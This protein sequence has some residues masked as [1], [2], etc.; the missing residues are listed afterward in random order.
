MSAASQLF[1]CRELLRQHNVEFDPAATGQWYFLFGATARQAGREDLAGAMFQEAL[2]HDPQLDVARE[3]LDG[4]RLKLGP[5]EFGIVPAPTVLSVSAGHVDIAPSAAAP[6]GEKA[7]AEELLRQALEHLQQSRYAD[8][9]R[10]LLQAVERRP[11]YAEAYAALGMVYAKQKRLG[12]AEACFRLVLQLQPPDA[13]VLADLGMICL[14]NNKATEAE[15]HLRQALLLAPNEPEILLR[16]ARTLAALHRG[17]EAESYLRTSLRLN[18]K[19]ADGQFLFGQWLHDQGKHEEA[20]PCLREALSLEPNHVDALNALGMVLESRGKAAEAESLYRRALALQPDLAEVHSNLGVALAEQ[21]KADE[22]EKEYRE[23]IRLKPDSAIAYSNL[24]NGL[25]QLGRLQEAEESLRHA[26]RLQR[27]YAEAHNNLG[28]VL[29]Q[30]GRRAEGKAC[31]EEALRLKPAYAD[32]HLNLGLYYLGEGDFERGWPEYEWRFKTRGATPRY[33]DRLAW[34]GAPFPGKTLLLH[35]EQGIGDTLQFIR[36]ARLAK[37]RGGNVA[38]ECPASLAGLFEKCPGVDRVFLRGEQPP[39]FDLHAPLMSL[40]GLLG[41]RLNTIPAPIPYLFPDEKGVRQWAQ[42]LV[43]IDGLRVGIVWQG[44]PQ[45]KGDRQRSAPLSAFAPLA[46]VPGVTLC[47]LQKDAGREQ[48]RT[49]EF[50]VEDFGARLKDQWSDTAA[51]V[52]NLDLLISV[53]TAVLHLAGAMGK[54][55]WGALPFAADWRWLQGRSDSP[56]Y[57]SIRLFRQKEAGNWKEVF[58]ALAEKLREEAARPRTRPI[59]PEP[60]TAAELYQCGSAYFRRGKVENALPLFE[61]AVALEPGR[62]DYCNSLGAALAK[63]KRLPEAEACFRQALARKPGDLALLGN[64]ALCCQEQGKKAEAE[65]VYRE[66]SERSPTSTEVRLKLAGVLRAQEKKKEAEAV[67]REVVRLQPNH[68]DA[69]NF[70]GILLEDTGKPKEAEEVYRQA[71]KVQPDVAEIHSNLGVALAAQDRLPEA[72]AAYR[73]ALRRRPKSAAAHNNLGNTLRMLGN[74]EEAEE[75]LLEAIRLKSDYAEA[76]NNLGVVH[77][78]AARTTE[79]LKNYDEALRLKPDYAEAHLNRSLA[80]LLQGDF[81]RGWEEYEWRWRGRQLK[82][83]FTQYPLWKGETLTGKTILLHAEQGLGD[84][85]QFVRYASIL[86]ERGARV[87][88]ECPESLVDLFRSCDGVDHVVQRGHTAPVVDFQIP[89]INVPGVLKTTMATIP[90]RVPYL[91]PDS[92]RVARWARELAG[93]GRIRV[94]IVWQGNP[95]HKGDRFRSVPLAM[96]APLAAVPD[97]ILCSIQKNHGREQLEKV[98]FR[99]EDFGE[100]V[101]SLADTAALMANLDLIISVDTAVVH[102]AGALARPVWVALPFAPDWRWLRDIEHSPW[103]PTLRHFRKRDRGDWSEVFSRLE[104]ALREFHPESRCSQAAPPPPETAQEWYQLGLVHYKRAQYANAIA[105]L[106]KAITLNPQCSDYYNSLGAAQAKMKRLAEAEQSFRKVL[107][108]KPELMPALGNLGLC[109]YEQGKFA[110]AEQAYREMTR[111]APT[112]PEVKQKLANLLRIQG[113]RQEA[114]ECYRDLLKLQ[115]KNVELLNS[116][117]ILLEEQG[118]NQ[119][120]IDVYRQALAIDPNAAEIHSNLG[121]A[122][123]G[124]ERLDQ[125]EAAYREAI[126]LKPNSAAA[127]NNLGNVLRKRGKVPEAEQ[128]LREALRLQA[129]YPEACNNLGIVLSHLG[130]YDESVACYQQALKLRPDYPEAL[131]NYG[132]L[133]AD[134][135]DADE[136]LRCYDEAIRIRPDYAEAHLNRALTY[137]VQGDF[138]RGWPEYEWRWKPPLWKGDAFTDRRWDGGSLKGCT[139]LLRAEQGQGDTIQF[140]RF[141]SCLKGQCEAQ[142]VIVEC[143]ESLAALLATCSGVDEVVVRGQRLPPFDW[144]VPM[145]SVPRLV[146]LDVEHPTTPMPYLKPAAERVAYWGTKLQAVDGVRVGIVWQGNPGYKGDRNRSLRLEQFERLAKIP[147]VQ[148]CS[149]QKG[150]GQE[151]IGEIRG[152]FSLIDFGSQLGDFADTAALMSNLDLVISVD[153]AP[154]HLAGALAIPVWI[155]LPFAND[156]RWFRQRA[157]TPWYPS[158]RLVRQATRRD[159]APVLSQL[160][161]MLREFSQH[162]TSRVRAV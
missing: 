142:R 70:L 20:E 8:A 100:E 158:M 30:Q 36:F 89:F 119:E 141:A 105:S 24:G 10:L 101:K 138:A 42:E 118:K 47:S 41:L 136:A 122:L 21:G 77:V 121:V 37:E 53:D 94:G 84:A 80:W 39:A 46:Q 129:N 69:L 26:L 120:A 81:E 82:A 31:Y 97:V 124:M 68:V 117:G 73:E 33:A 23:S 95:Q 6:A 62:I 65:L 99:L 143:Q 156:W 75:H 160:E 40:A 92:S 91:H 5:S 11:G 54:P 116:L 93:L 67:Y 111:L 161:D 112:S 14:E 49:V 45:H 123:A 145:L 2:R 27:Q 66:M 103:Y 22:A 86:K 3:Q 87:V 79:A 28:I 114:A 7:E 109:C 148:L 90:S 19:S 149:L 151:Q 56:W 60:Q 13:A 125:A 134:R 78:Q 74:I 107:Q 35:T 132:I 72:E 110:E 144:Q 146:N 76:F 85:I 131:N 63:L 133:L 12:D 52:A 71:L 128:S 130:R 51:L 139:V 58:V 9:E 43:G 106:E 64:L 44:N 83:R 108:L 155:P 159:W 135:H 55:A 140:V 157:D 88:V 102:L 127:H 1:S 38:V 4:A 50:G 16:L 153:T 48:L 61:K 29:V 150:A 32:A 57:P 15:T 113:K 59:P 25:R 147:G 115:P 17:A 18:P 162:R 126:R 96:F 152:R 137:L 104:K 154:A 34:D 98:S